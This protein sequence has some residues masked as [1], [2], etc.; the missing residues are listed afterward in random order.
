MTSADDLVKILALRLA[1]TD[2]KSVSVHDD[3]ILLERTLREAG[4]LALVEAAYELSR[5]LD[6]PVHDVTMINL[7][8]EQLRAA[9]SRIERGKDV[10]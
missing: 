1:L 9:W 7:R 6:S 8:R 5:E 2:G 10:K 4:L 3:A